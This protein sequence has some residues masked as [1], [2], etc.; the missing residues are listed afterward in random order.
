[1]FLNLFKL[2]LKFDSKYNLKIVIQKVELFTHHESMQKIAE[3]L[4]ENLVRLCCVNLIDSQHC[5]DPGNIFFYYF[6]YIYFS[7]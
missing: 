1:M 3:K 4:G 7:S 5:S 6:E 2:N